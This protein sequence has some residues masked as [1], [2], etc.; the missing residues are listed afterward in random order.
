MR[1]INLHYFFGEIFI[2]K[3]STEKRVKVLQI[4][5]ADSSRKRFS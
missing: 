3:P 1:E 4:T 2:N 5:N